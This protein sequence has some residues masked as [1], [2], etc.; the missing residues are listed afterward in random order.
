MNTSSPS[1]DL[2]GLPLRYQKLSSTTHSR[3]FHF[4]CLG[5]K[6]VF[7]MLIESSD[8]GDPESFRETEL[9]KKCQEIGIIP[10]SEAELAEKA[11]ESP[12]TIFS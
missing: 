10:R 3:T 11:R 4:C 7:H 6:Q 9:F 8:A 2:C 1:C 5:C 12:T